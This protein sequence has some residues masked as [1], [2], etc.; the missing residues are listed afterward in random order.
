MTERRMSWPN[1]WVMAQRNP[2][3]VVSVLSAGFIV[4]AQSCWL[5]MSVS[6]IGEN[7]SLPFVDQ[8]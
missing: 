4:V 1:F 3:I 5:E 7:L 2:P 6:F 8:S